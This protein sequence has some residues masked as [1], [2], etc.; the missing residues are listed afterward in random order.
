MKKSKRLRLSSKIQTNASDSDVD[1]INEESI[2]EKTNNNK[3]LIK[4]NNLNSNIA[5]RSKR[6]KFNFDSN[7]SYCNLILIIFNVNDFKSNLY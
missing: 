5:V 7:F 6:N 1:L 3:N 4:K 2:C